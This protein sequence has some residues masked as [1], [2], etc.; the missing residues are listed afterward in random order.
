MVNAVAFSPDNHLLASASSD[1][2]I[3]LWS[4][5]DHRKVRTLLGHT[6]AVN[7]VAFSPDGRLLASGA[8][9]HTVRL[10]NVRTG[11]QIRQLDAQ[12]AVKGVAFNTSGTLLAT[13]GADG[14]VRVWNPETGRQV[15]EF[16]GHTGPIWSV[17]FSPNRQTL[18]SGSEDKTVRTWD[19]TFDSWL[20]DGCKL[21]NRNLSISEWNELIPGF[22]YHRTCPNLPSGT[23]APPDAPAATY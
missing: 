16:T 14:T 7:A 11:A 3:V 22:P 5:A 9:D 10:W 21:V 23:G 19:L 6:N 20:P 2:S 15:R 12:A 4:P 17:A 13:G 1:Q 18:A 8:E